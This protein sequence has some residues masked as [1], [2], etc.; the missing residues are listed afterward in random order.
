MYICVCSV[1][2]YLATLEA[3][4]HHVTSGQLN[5]HI[6]STTHVLLLLLLLL[7]IVVITYFVS[8]IQ[9]ICVHSF[10]ALFSYSVNF[11]ERKQLCFQHVLAI[12]ILFVRLSVCH[13][14]GSGKNGPS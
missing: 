4:L 13:T 10:T 11:Y 14:G 7:L 1:R 2:F 5:T 3:A 8:F 6:N 9:S 12:V